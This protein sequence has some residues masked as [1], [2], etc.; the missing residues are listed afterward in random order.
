MRLI[1]LD[2]LYLF[3]HYENIFVQLNI[4]SFSVIPV[5]VSHDIKEL[6]KVFDYAIC[7]YMVYILTM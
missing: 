6:G 3:N 1:M 5:L 4:Q 2:W 7:E